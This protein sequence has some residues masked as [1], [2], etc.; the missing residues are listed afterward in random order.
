GFRQP[1]IFH[2]YEFSKEKE[3][4]QEPKYAR[5]SL[6][7]DQA[8]NSLKR[9]LSLMELEKPYLNSD[10]KIQYLAEKIE[11]S[12]HHLSQIINENLNQNFADFINSYRINE[13][14]RL[15]LSPNYEQEKI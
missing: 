2:G 10:L 14:K 3:K 1:E 5:S 15:L 6:T 11:V 13:A 9:L 4:K 12:S 7:E 8:K